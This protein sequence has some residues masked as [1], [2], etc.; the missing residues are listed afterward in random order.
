MLKPHWADASG[1]EAYPPRS[2]ARLA[3]RSY[4]TLFFT[5]LPGWLA[6]FALHDARQPAA[7]AFASVVGPL[8][9]YG[10]TAWVIRRYFQRATNVPLGSLFRVL[11]GRQWALALTIAAFLAAAN[12]IYGLAFGYRPFQGIH[13]NTPL[14]EPALVLFLALYVAGP[15]LAAPWVE[16][17]LFR[18]L[19]FNAL[20]RNGSLQRAAVLSAFLFAMAH[21]NYR[22]F[23]THFLSGIAFALIYYRT[24]NLSVSMLAHMTYNALVTLI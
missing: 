21:A 6:V 22:F 23:P 14:Q 10:A 11:D 4:L 18:A 17:L 3:W 1:D 8:L 19:A 20:L 2:T 13:V 5:A 9:S 16:E 12:L 7:E 24:N 15:L